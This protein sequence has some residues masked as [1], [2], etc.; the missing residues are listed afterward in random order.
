MKTGLLL[1]HD[2][3]Y[4][5][6]PPDQPWTLPVITDNL[7]ID[8]DPN[9]WVDTLFGFGSVVN[10]TSGTVA[11]NAPIGVVHWNISGAIS[12]DQFSPKNRCLFLLTRM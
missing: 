11:D 6:S 2:T 10:T 3:I 9:Q 8:D 4:G 12:V 1:L 7:L 5:W